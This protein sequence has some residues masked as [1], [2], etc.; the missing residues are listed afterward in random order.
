MI[1]FREVKEKFEKIER[2]GNPAEY[3][4]LKEELEFLELEM[5]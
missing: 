5:A 4:N 3:Q 1:N 2:E